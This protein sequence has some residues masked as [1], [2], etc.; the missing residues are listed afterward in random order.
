MTVSIPRLLSVLLGAD[1]CAI[2][3]KK[4]V[5]AMNFLDEQDHCFAVFR[6][7]LNSRMKLLSKG[8]RYQS[9]TSLSDYTGGWGQNLDWWSIQVRLS[10]SSTVYTFITVRYSV[11]WLLTNTGYHSK[12]NTSL[13][14]VRQELIFTVI[15][16]VTLWQD[17]NS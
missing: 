9:K 7:V 14:T 3:K 15:P 10:S 5:H 12:I 8:L 16:R 13:S 11:W 1:Y 2:C 4:N 17:S 6:K